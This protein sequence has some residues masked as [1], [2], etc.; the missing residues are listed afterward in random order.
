MT[1]YNEVTVKFK[2]IN[3]W[4]PQKH[5]IVLRQDDNSP[6][7]YVAVAVPVQEITDVSQAQEILKK[8]T[9]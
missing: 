9:K 6:S 3:G 8:F 1:V 5:T 4:D 7:G 2:E